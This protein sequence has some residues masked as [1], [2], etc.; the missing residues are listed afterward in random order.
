MLSKFFCERFQSIEHSCFDQ[1]AHEG[2]KFHNY[3]PNNKPI[4]CKLQRFKHF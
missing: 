1:I 2:S 4:E 3:E